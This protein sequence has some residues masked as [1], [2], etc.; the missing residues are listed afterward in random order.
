[1]KNGKTP[2]FN[3]RA[4]GIQ[5]ISEINRLV[6]DKSVNYCVK[7]AGG[8]FGTAQEGAS[9]LFPDV[10]LFGD[11]SERLIIQ[12]WELKTP[13]TDIADVKL[14]ANA[15]EKARRMNTTSFIVWNGRV[16]VL[17]VL[18]SGGDWRESC[19]WTDPAITSRETLGRMPEVWKATLRSIIL[20]IEELVSKGPI[21]S[22]ARTTDQLDGLVTAVLNAT[23]NPIEESLHKQYVSNGKFRASLDAWW[24]S[25][26]GE[27][28]DIKTPNEA[29][30]VSV[31]A[32]ETA[33]HWAS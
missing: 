8:E 7:C 33:Y 24:M 4:W 12:G 23:Q 31:K 27:H 18:D 5:I 22:A 17:Y 30:A 11:V 15:K 25:V 32:S 13:E 26:R 9:T 10:L 1:M 28:P 6:S 3:E 20:K 21:L 14:L 19:R 16:A 2:V 29:A